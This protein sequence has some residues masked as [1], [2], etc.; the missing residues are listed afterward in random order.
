MESL[1]PK[2][3]VELMDAIASS[4][5]VTV[6]EIF[7]IYTKGAAIDRCAIGILTIFGILIFAASV[8]HI[9]KGCYKLNEEE[10]ADG[11]AILFVGAVKCVLVAICIV[12]VACGVL[13]VI[14]A[15]YAPEYIAI[16]TMLTDF[17][18]LMP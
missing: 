6:G 1:I 4:I 8:W 3:M 10:N 5:G 13:D 2:S 12:F 9:G 14:M 15:I 11:E 16:Q 17:S 7:E 18:T